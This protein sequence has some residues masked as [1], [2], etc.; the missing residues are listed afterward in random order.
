MQYRELTA[1][2]QEL[3]A[4][5]FEAIQRN[6]WPDHHEVGAAVRAGSGKIYVGVHLESPGVDVCAE[7]S[8]VGS[9]A[10]AGER[11]LVCVAAANRSEVMPPC[12]VCREL[13]HYFSPHMD[14]VVPTD[15]GPRKVK[16]ADLL[17][18][19]YAEPRPPQGQ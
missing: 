15:D 10:A 2:D 7:W 4:A 19:P 3:V 8:A 11:E 6:H 18:I 17:P 1:E 13:L 14:V 16:I 5:A 12:G 9:A